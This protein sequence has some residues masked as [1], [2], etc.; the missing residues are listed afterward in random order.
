MCESAGIEVHTV[1]MPVS[2][3]V[4]SRASQQG[5]RPTMKRSVRRPGTAMCHNPNR[6]IPWDALS[7]GDDP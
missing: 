5:E 2:K 7:G 4:L 6:G 1:A 3:L